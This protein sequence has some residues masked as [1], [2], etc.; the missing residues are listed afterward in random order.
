MV[1]FAGFFFAKKQKLKNS[2]IERRTLFFQKILIFVRQVAN[3]LWCYDSLGLLYTFKKPYGLPPPQST[4]MWKA[5]LTF[6]KIK[7]NIDNLM[8]VWKRMH[9]H[10]KFYWMGLSHLIM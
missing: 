3:L 6:K 2:I 1:I 8:S 5:T 4:Y 9:I 7:M 10:L